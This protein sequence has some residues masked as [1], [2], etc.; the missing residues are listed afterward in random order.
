[1][2]LSVGDRLG[3]F[4]ILGPLGAGGM[5]DVYRAR[6]P[7]LQR[8]VAIKVLPAAFSSDPDR[9]RRFE[10]EA[11]SAGSL[12]HPNI[13]AVH[14]VVV[15]DGS[16]CIVTELLEGQT[17]RERMNGRALPPRKALEYAIQVA[18]GLAAAARGRSSAPARFAL[19]TTP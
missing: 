3:R 19:P 8:E 18:S 13:V 11:R 15:H 9:R 4:E 10:Q 14:D 16:A 5:G 17:L 7:Q 2:D 12:N 1:M 6:D